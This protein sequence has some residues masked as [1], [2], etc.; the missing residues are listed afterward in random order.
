MHN[1]KYVLHSET[2]DIV[3]QSVFKKYDDDGSGELDIE[4]FS[5]ALN[6]LGVIDEHE[7][8][9]IF[10]LADADNGGTVCIN[11]FIQLI[12]GHEFDNI[13]ASHDEL[14]FIYQTHK[15]FEKYDADGNGEISWE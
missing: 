3:L 6:D 12:K 8:K 5:D 11:E 10:H 9:A 2:P 4:E 7:Q 15:Q 1:A 13:L 14:E